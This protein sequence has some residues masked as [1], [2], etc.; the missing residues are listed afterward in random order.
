AVRALRPDGL[1][2]AAR[3]IMT[4]DLVPKTARAV[5]R[6]GGRRVT[7]AGIAKG[8]GMI[9]PNMATMLSFLVTDA[10]VPP[11][12]LRRLLR[13]TA[14]V[15]YNRVTVDGECSTSDTVLLLAGGRAGHPP[16]ASEREAGTR[17]FAD[18]LREVATELAR[19]IAR[20][21]EGAT[22]LV[23]VRVTGARSAA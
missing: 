1:R 7:V 10:V 14:D 3:A 16:L 21:G 2:R 19:A 6:I 13:A 17:R 11:A 20:D 15:T 8:S 12:L 23:T 9:E 22:R 5:T 4:T 18:A